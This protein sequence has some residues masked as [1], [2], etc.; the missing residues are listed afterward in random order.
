MSRLLVTATIVLFSVMLTGTATEEVTAFTFPRG[1]QPDRYFVVFETTPGEGE[2]Q[3]VQ[4]A[5]GKV[6]H[7]YEIVPAVSAYLTERSLRAL[8][9]N[10]LVVHV[11]PVL[12]VFPVSDDGDSDNVY[13]WGADHIGAAEAHE[14]GY[15]GEGVDI[16]VLD[17]G[18][19]PDHSWLEIESGVDCT[20][21]GCPDGQ[22]DRHGHGTHV[23]GTIAASE[24]SPVTG[25]APDA[26]LHSVKVLRAFD[27]GGF[28]DDIL[29]GLDWAADNDIQITNNS[30]GFDSEPLGPTIQQAY[31]E[32]YDSGILHITSAGNTG[33]PGGDGDLVMIPARYDVIVAVAATEPDDSRRE[34]S[35]TGPCL[36]LAAPG[37]SIESTSPDGETRTSSGTS[38]AA[39]HVSG[40]AALV[41][42]EHPDLS[43]QDIRTILVDTARDLGDH[44]QFGH[45]LVQAVDAIEYAANY[46]TGETPG[47]VSPECEG[48]GDFYASDD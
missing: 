2:I 4:R 24:E 28:T 3:A 29:A 44:D 15:T 43:H 8:E 30:Y 9:R 39:P 16:A 27:T 33:E 11:E 18:V 12:E 47:F 17:T 20:E 7:S 41:W 13:Q 1:E 37:S 21:P 48:I 46:T 10:D 36:E 23:A 35:S 34:S 5:G 22:E 42:A 40:V 14:N 25:V 31:S 26:N 38:M 45:G 19:D 32:T 6:R